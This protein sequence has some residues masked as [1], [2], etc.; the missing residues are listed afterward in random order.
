MSATFFSLITQRVVVV[1]VVVVVVMVV[2]VTYKINAAFFRSSFIKYNVIY[3]SKAHRGSR[4]TAP[5]I[6]LGAR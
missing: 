1:V 2:V 4:G 6:N 5:L 3:A